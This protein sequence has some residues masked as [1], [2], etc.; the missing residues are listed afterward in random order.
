MSEAGRRR[1]WRGAAIAAV[2][3]GAVAGAWVG[4][5]R[6]ALAEPKPAAAPDDA[7]VWVRPAEPPAPSVEVLPAAAASPALPIPSVPDPVVPAAAPVAI[8]LPA[9]PASPR[10]LDTSVLGNGIAPPVIPPLPP[11]P[12]PPEVKPVLPPTGAEVPPVDVQP[13]NPSPVLPPPTPL[14]PQAPSPS[15]IPPVGDLTPPSAPAQSPEPPRPPGSGSAD[16]GL[17]RGNSEN[18]VKPDNV[19][20]SSGPVV[21][22]APVIPAPEPL[23]PVLPTPPPLGLTVPAVPAVGS[24]GEAPGTTV[25]RS[26]P[27]PNP[28]TFPIPNTTP[29]ESTMTAI[30]S[31]TAAVLGGLL[32]APASPA[33]AVPPPAPIIPVPTAVAA[34]G[35]PDAADLKKQLDES[36]KKLD[37]IQDQL[38]QLAELLNGRRDDRGF[39]LESDPGLVEEV[40]RL[41]DRLAALEA[42]L[43]KVKTQTALRPVTPTDQQAGKGTVRVVNEYPVQISIVVNGTS[44]RIAPNRTQDIEVPAGEFT[45]QLLE[46]GAASTKSAIKERET[47]TLRIK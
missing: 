28:V 46:A 19:G 3:G 6:P 21:P 5:I 2:A 37:A 31:A 22:V 7:A 15:A 10:P 24:P 38:K 35:Q 25:D 43:S 32:F 45:Y 42:D 16:S 13:V 34:Q 30:H 18:T 20:G 17:P 29:G 23:N 14:V 33:R 12:K 11:V 8:P 39:R 47:V 4:F 9:E 1:W 40:K 41:K 44:Y 27:A 26:R 36:N